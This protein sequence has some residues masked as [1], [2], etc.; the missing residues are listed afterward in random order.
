M[1]DAVRRAWLPTL[2]FGL[3]IFFLEQGILGPRWSLIG[4]FTLGAL[5]AVPTIWCL[6]TAR[7]RRVS[8]GRGVLVGAL[9]GFGIVLIQILGFEIRFAPSRGSGSLAGATWGLVLAMV[10]GI[11]VPFGAGV[12]ALTALLQKPRRGRES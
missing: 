5:L 3:P 7:S 2:L 9:C 12:G 6:G 4:S 8:V 11:L 10:A 1:I